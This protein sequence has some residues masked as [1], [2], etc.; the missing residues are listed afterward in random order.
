MTIS[1]IVPHHSDGRP[2][3]RAARSRI[4]TMPLSVDGPVTRDKL[5]VAGEHSGRPSTPWTAEMTIEGNQLLRRAAEGDVDALRSLLETYGPQV[6]STIHADIGSR[7]RSMLDADDVMQVTYMEAFLQ[8]DRL[9]ARDTT[10]FLG[11]LRSIARNN[12]RDAVKELERKK[13]PDPARRVQAPPGADSY[14]A[15]VEMLGATTATPSRHVAR[16]EAAD[17]IESTL[18]RLPPDYATVIQLYDLEGRPIAEVATEMGR[19]SG[20]VHML[21]AR[22]HDQLRSMLGTETNFFTHPA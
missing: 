3:H 13:R 5:L 16:Q 7:H 22:A 4:T 1:G 17:A 21:R 8:V 15:L 2:C 19:S 12:L 11:W 6:W 18:R 14:V 20:A 10:A 9:H